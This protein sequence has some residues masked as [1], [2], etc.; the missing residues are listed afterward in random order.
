VKGVKV[1]PER[2]QAD[3]RREQRPVGDER[4]QKDRRIRQG[5]IFALGYTL[6]RFKRKSPPG[7]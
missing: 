1:I 4:R 6:F 5:K 7:R 2:R 3:R